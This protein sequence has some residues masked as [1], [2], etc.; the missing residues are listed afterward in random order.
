[1]GMLHVAMSMHSNVSV[2]STRV[3]V[4]VGIERAKS[5]IF[6]ALVRHLEAKI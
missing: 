3:V 4:L 1:M 2:R 5:V 6:I